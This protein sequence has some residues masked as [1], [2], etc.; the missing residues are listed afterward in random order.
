M[1]VSSNINASQNPFKNNLSQYPPVQVQQVQ[2]VQQVPFATPFG[3]YQNIFG[4]VAPNNNPYIPQQALY[5]SLFGNAGGQ[6]QRP[7]MESYADD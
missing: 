2:Q 7:D 1:N 6:E 5:F 4:N 3:S